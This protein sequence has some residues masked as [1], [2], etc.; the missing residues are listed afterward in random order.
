MA[1]HLATT[2]NHAK[3]WWFFLRHRPS[4]GLAFAS[5]P[6]ACA[7]RALDDLRLSLVARH[8]RAFIALDLI[9]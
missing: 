8:H 1:Y 6:T 4:T 9:G 5:A 7:P 3:D 2:L